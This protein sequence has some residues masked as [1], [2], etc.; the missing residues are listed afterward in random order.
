MR[1]FY[2]GWPNLQTPSADLVQS[3]IRQTPSAKSGPLPHF[4][5]PW[6]HYV[7]LL[8]VAAPEAR[9]YY[10]RE[11]LIGAWSARQLD[12][13][14][15]T[16]AYQK[17]RGA[18]SPAPKADISRSDA[19]VREPFVLE[20]LNLKDE[21]SETELESALIQSLQQFL[22]ELGNDFAFIAR[23][24]GCVSEPSGTGLIWFSFTGGFGA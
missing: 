11:S 14:I 8:S 13:Q 3:G 12:R 5:L 21:Y 19:H 7:R 17:T 4:P 22:L 9:A 6:S 10:E 2:L 20:F 16:L 18:R 15:S 1:L 24:N 23:K